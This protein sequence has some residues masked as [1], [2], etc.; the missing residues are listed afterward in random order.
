VQ[1][2]HF[3]SKSVSILNKKDVEEPS[4]LGLLDQAVPGT[5]KRMPLQY[6][7]NCSLHGPLH[8]KFSYRHDRTHL[9]QIAARQ[10][11]SVCISFCIFMEHEC[12]GQLRTFVEGSRSGEGRGL[13]LLP[14]AVRL[15]NHHNYLRKEIHVL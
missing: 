3:E 4:Q 6:K 14:Q 11:T 2:Q 13:E 15:S 8:V 12:H 1:T 7:T 10:V 5:K 9:R